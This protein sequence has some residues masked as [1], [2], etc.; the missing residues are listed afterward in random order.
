VRVR[1]QITPVQHIDLIVSADDAQGR[2]V[3]LAHSIAL[4]E[5]G[6]IAARPW[7]TTPRGQP[8]AEAHTNPV[9]C[10]IDGRAPFVRGSIEPGL[11]RPN[12]EK[13]P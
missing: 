9:C 8:D 10:Y 13:I 12:F 3:E 6:W 5:S 1:S 2:R 11:V 7:S 4:P